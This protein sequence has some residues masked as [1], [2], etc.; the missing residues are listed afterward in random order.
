VAAI[1]NLALGSLR[2]GRG[3]ALGG[4]LHA[5]VAKLDLRAWLGQGRSLVAICHSGV[6]LGQIDF[7]AVAGGRSL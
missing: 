1:G 3:G 2:A 6:V 5:R 7:A 4:A